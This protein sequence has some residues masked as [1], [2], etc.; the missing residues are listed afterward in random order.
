[1]GW[2]PKFCNINFWSI[3]V[4][5]WNWRVTDENGIISTK[6]LKSQNIG[7]LTSINFIN[8]VRK[9]NIVQPVCDGKFTVQEYSTSKAMGLEYGKLADKGELNQ[10]SIKFQKKI[11]CPHASLSFCWGFEVET[12]INK[13]SENYG[14]IRSQELNRIN[15]RI[16]TNWCTLSYR[17]RMF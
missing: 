2:Q 11:T 12:T 17:E 7:W 1:M 13:N 6:Q 10:I 15:L 4:D 3:V 14:K 16:L 8:I 9:K 5:I